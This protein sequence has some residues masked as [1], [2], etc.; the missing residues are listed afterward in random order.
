MKIVQ[1]NLNHCWNALDV[2]KQYTLE[3]DIGLCAISEPP[4]RIADTGKW[5]SSTNGSAAIMWISERTRGIAC[6]LIRR[7]KFSVVAYCKG[8]YFISSYISPN[9]PMNTFHDF[10]DKLD[11]LILYISSKF[12][13]C[14]DFNS[15]AT[16]WGCPS[17]DRRGNKL[18]NWAA[19]R[20]LRL[21]NS[22]KLPT[23]VGA[24]GFS[25]VDLTWASPGLAGN[26]RD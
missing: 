24:Q 8:I 5:F 23:F 25:I 15:K 10:L 20:D 21:L 17:S 12:I 13:I 7:G 9:A 26:V 18:V 19:T 22:G 16:L 6:S 2:L 11:S 14:G 4:P 1:C 3:N